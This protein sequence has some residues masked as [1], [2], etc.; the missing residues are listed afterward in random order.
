MNK[1]T[2]CRTNLLHDLPA[3]TDAFG[4]HQR[5]AEALA[6]IVTSEIGGKAIA[7]TGTWGSGKSTVIR[8]LKMALKQQGNSSETVF[9]F[10]AW[11]HEQDPLRRAFLERLIDFL[12][13]VEWVD[14]ADWEST[15][16]S[17]ARRVKTTETSETPQLTWGGVSFAAALLLAPIGWAV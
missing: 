1:P 11:S 5:V 7:L 8:L 2:K 3:D 4:S 15:K 9:V 6:H 13:D 12:S 17:L 10:D 14:S 16:A